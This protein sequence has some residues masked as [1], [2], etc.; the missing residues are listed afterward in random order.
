MKTSISTTTCVQCATSENETSTNYVKH[1]TKTGYLA[2]VCVIRISI[3]VCKGLGTQ[4]RTSYW[5]R[6]FLS[7]LT[8]IIALEECTLYV[9]CSRTA[10]QFTY[11]KLILI[12]NMKLKLEFD[13]VSWTSRYRPIQIFIHKYNKKFTCCR[14]A[15]G[16]SVSLFGTRTQC[17]SS[18]LQ[19]SLHSKKQFTCSTVLTYDECKRKT[20]GRM[21]GQNCCSIILNL[22]TQE[23]N[24]RYIC[25]GLQIFLHDEYLSLSVRVSPSRCMV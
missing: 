15:A 20:D 4:L 18:R 21:D 17:I 3:A 10:F 1:R 8:V 22:H 25:Q 16:H 12:Y 11:N 9:A 5:R 19:A 6:I 14:E 7:G 13:F 2:T 24:M 23:N